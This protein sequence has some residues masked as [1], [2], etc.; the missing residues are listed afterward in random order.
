MDR[1]E[2]LQCRDRQR[3]DFT[4]VDL[5]GQDLRSLDLRHCNLRQAKLETAHL[6]LANL[7]KA[8]L[9]KVQ[10]DGADF[11]QAIL[12]DV[13]GTNALFNGAN[14]E[15][16]ILNHSD[17]HKAQL[18]QARLT[19][20]QLEQVRLTQSDLTGAQ[21]GESFATEV[22][23]KGA[24]LTGSNWSKAQLVRADLSETNLAQCDF[25]G[26]DLRSA[27]LQEAILDGT[28]FSET[29]LRGA[30]LTWG[31][32]PLENAIFTGAI[33]PD[34]VAF[35]ENW[36]PPQIQAKP[37]PYLRPSSPPQPQ[38]LER[39][40]RFL[41]V[42]PFFKV[43]DVGPKKPAPPKTIQELGQRLPWTGLVGLVC[44]YAGWGA[45]MKLLSAPMAA[46]AL[47]LLGSL[48]PAA[49]IAAIPYVP[50]I[51]YLAILLSLA[52]TFSAFIAATAIV[53]GLA[54]GISGKISVGWSSA[55]A[56]QASLWC[57]EGVVSVIMLFLFVFSGGSVSYASLS[58]ALLSIFGTALVTL[59][60]LAWPMMESEGLTT[61][62]RSIVSFLVTASGLA[63]GYF[64][65]LPG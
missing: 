55:E 19:K 6:E 53:V 34:G 38:T 42:N 51:G 20:A 64:L 37:V 41:L 7:A 28:N 26:A 39:P 32:N 1:D 3:T 33:M 25:Q 57:M 50:F 22:T 60:A 47:I 18:T 52:P 46:I 4:W 30:K 9:I 40:N 31:E 63:L 24:Q 58:I 17:L 49:E 29:D 5:R 43:P 44:A 54:L 2:L 12:N 13:R 8:S 56:I 15:A 61:K 48:M 23:L 14:F 59:C 16:A 11:S 45:V 10:A 27:N 21:C 62:Q 65:W 35:D 36:Q